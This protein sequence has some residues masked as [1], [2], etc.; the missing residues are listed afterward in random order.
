MEPM[1]YQQIVTAAI[2]LLAIVVSLVSLRRTSRV[3]EQQLRLQRKQEELTDLQ[4]EALRKQSQTAPS[5]ATSPAATQEKA[6]VRI[7]LTRSGRDFR[8]IIT[9]WGRVPA[10]DVTFEL[11]LEA[12]KRSPLVKGDYNEKI[13]IPELAPGNR[14]PLWAAI[15]MGMA[16]TFPARWS[17]RNPDGSVETRRSTMAI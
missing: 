14:V 1:T 4:L 10:R 9:N 17:W 11:D 5:L 13:P 3:Q 8:F 6:D 15:T 7:D 16:S 2:A 12:G